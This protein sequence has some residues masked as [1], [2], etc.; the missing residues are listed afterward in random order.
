MQGSELALY[1]HDRLK[2]TGWERKTR[3]LRVEKKEGSVG[4][5]TWV[6]AEE[7]DERVRESV[8]ERV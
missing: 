1:G 8:R 7:R 4:R 6:G 5:D 2:H 3:Q